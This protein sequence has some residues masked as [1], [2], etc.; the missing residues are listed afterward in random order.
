MS[1]LLASSLAESVWRRL[2][3]AGDERQQPLQLRLLLHR[4]VVEDVAVRLVKRLLQI[5]AAAAAVVVV[6]WLAI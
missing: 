3:D 1:H 5:V 2:F 4:S 6:D